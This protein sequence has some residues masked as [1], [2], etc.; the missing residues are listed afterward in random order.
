M[1]GAAGNAVETSDARA[2]NL[3]RATAA[4]LGCLQGAVV[5][6]LPVFCEVAV[7]GVL[8]VCCGTKLSKIDC[9]C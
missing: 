2:F 6:V 1:G 3:R 4:V 9:N 7:V 8:P 5:L